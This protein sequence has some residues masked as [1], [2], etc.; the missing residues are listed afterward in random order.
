MLI[1]MVLGQRYHVIIEANPKYLIKQN[2]NYDKPK[3]TVKEEWA[4]GDYIDNPEAF[5]IRTIAA[6]G[7]H[8][9]MLGGTPDERQ[10]ILLY[11]NN[12]N[13]VTP[14]TGRRNFSL[15][16]RDEENLKPWKKWFVNGTET[17]AEKHK[18]NTGTQRQKGIPAA[19]DNFAK[20]TIGPEPMFLNF[21]DPTIRELNRPVESWAEDWAKTRVIIP[22][23]APKD[24]WV[25]LAIIS[26]EKERHVD[27]R[28]M[29]PAAHPVS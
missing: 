12:T 13:T 4:Y 26:D 14:T 20:W 16:C 27:T 23:T 29:I 28:E 9:F 1:V 25:Y 3:G 8:K 22:E 24:S 21:S 10:G 17:I 11:G 7:C 6:D 19:T 15:L 18:F 2:G 5:W